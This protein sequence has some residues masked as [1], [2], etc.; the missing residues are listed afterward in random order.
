MSKV[1]NKAHVEKFK[2]LFSSA[3]YDT[4]VFVIA[5][6]PKQ[7]SIDINNITKNNNIFIPFIFLFKI[8]IGNNP[9]QYLK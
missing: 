3:P 1:Y 9:F 4:V 6:N 7:I 5:E 2:I 8:L